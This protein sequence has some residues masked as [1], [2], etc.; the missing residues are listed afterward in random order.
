[1]SAALSAGGDFAEIFVESCERSSVS[2]INSI[3]EKA[4]WGIGYGCGIRVIS[5]FG[6]IYTYTNDT[7]PENLIK[8]A[9]EASLA[10]KART[11]ESSGIQT[12]NRLDV[13]SLHPIGIHPASADKSLVVEKLR[14]A[15]S[16]AYKH[17]KFITQT[18]AGFIGYTQKVL[19]ANS[20]GLWANDSRTRTRVTFEAIA[21]NEKE[22]QVGF[23][24][25]GAHKG[26][27]FLDDLD[28][29]EI[30][31]ECAETASVMLAADL[32][33]GGLMPVIIDNGFGGVIFHEACGHSLEA[34][35]VAVKASVFADRLGEQIASEKVTAIDDGTIP[36][37]WGSTNIDDE[38]SPT[39]KNILIE[40]GILKSYMIDRLN[41]L[42]MGMPA[43]GSS[44][45][46]SY[47]Y[48][49]VS[50]MTNTYIAS[51]SDSI[52]DIIAST[53]YGLYAKKMGGGSVQPATG[54]F[55]FAVVEGYMVRGGKLAEPVRGATLIGRGSEVLMNID[56]VSDNL[57]LGQGMCGASSGTVPANVGQPMIR[58]KKLTVGG[59][60]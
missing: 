30:G 50:R 39:R 60:R 52:A 29:E 57:Q 59:R 26:L 33:P 28:M 12:T 32:C 49:P 3:V 41:G 38:G 10:A 6:A 9:R 11:S 45:R 44:R 40:K 47:H 51:G 20:E 17:S 31:T 24:G 5:G 19:I 2:M 4:L 36:N 55:N 14:Q 43:T 23:K 15:S 25:P 7:S 46:E 8:C 16:A 13:E 21:S 56:M 22:K 37:S 53:E 18:A 34:A 42:K 58:V 54:D 27:E 35:A 1:M 48:A